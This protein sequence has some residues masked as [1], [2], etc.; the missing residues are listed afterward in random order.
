MSDRPSFI[1]VIECATGY[2]CVNWQPVP[3]PWGLENLPT[4]FSTR[5]V[6]REFAKRF[7]HE[8][9]ANR[10]SLHQH[11]QMYVRYRVRRYIRE[12]KK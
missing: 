3:N 11:S 8:S 1:W 2:D 9:S 4:I 5:S 10:S 12:V 7:Q 6:A